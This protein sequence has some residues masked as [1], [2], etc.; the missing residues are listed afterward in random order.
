MTVNHWL[1]QKKE[2]E[3]N[4]LYTGLFD[5]KSPNTYDTEHMEFNDRIK[6]TRQTKGAESWIGH[7]PIINNLTE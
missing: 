4:D 1:N 5:S 2:K 6:L 7:G 3:N